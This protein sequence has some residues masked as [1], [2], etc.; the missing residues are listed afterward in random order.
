[1]EMRGLDSARGADGMPC[2]A[3]EEA[4]TLYHSSR[5]TGELRVWLLDLMNN[6]LM[7]E[8]K[9]HGRT[10]WRRLEFPWNFPPCG[11]NRLLP[12]AG[13]KSGSGL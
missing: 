2:S 6:A 5:P 7:E 9:Y 12:L 11:R 1:M 10:V 3:L 13:V 4:E 8:Y